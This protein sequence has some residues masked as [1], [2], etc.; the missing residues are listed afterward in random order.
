M[1]EYELEHQNT[2]EYKKAVEVL[3]NTFSH[4][5]FK[6]YQYRIINNI[7]K[8]NDVLAVMPTGYGKSLCFQLPPLITNELA[9]VISPLIALMA[10]QKAIMDDLGINSC[11]YNS[12]LTIKNKKAI[13]NDLIDGKYQIMYITPESLVNLH[14]LIDKIYEKHGICMIAI[15]EAHCLSSYGFDFRPKYLEIVNIRKIL[16]NV[17]VLAVTATAT[18]NVIVDIQRIMKMKNNDFITTS[19]DRPNLTINVNV[20][21]KN[22]IDQIVDI[23][24]GK[25]DNSKLLKSNDTKKIIVKKN[26]LLQ[27]GSS[28]VYCLTRKDTE[29]ITEQL[30]SLGI[31]TIAYHSGLTKMERDHAQMD[32][33]NDKYEC[34]AATLAFGMGINKPN[35][36]T[37]IHYGCPQNIESY[38][39]EIGRAGR[40]GEKSTCYLFYKQRDFIIQQKFINDIQDEKYKNHKAHLLSQISKY[41]SHNQCRR[42]YILNYFGQQPDFDNCKNCDVCNSVKQKIM[43]K[44]TNKDDYKIFQILNTILNIQVAKGFSFGSSTIALILKGSNSQK[45]KPWMKELTYFSAFKCETIDNVGKLI[46]TCHDLGYIE[47]HDIGNCIKVLQCTNEGIAFGTD[48]ESK[49][50]DMINSQNI[51]KLLF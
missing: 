48:Y 50:Q 6:P 13:E 44:K 33:M 5:S 40:D 15:D 41:V 46:Q 26:N 11:C 45:I 27:K 21:S 47:N 19:F 30:T 28:I 22:T 17:P 37:V 42:K 31:S 16:K 18:N 23:L 4:S 2:K 29:N 39:Q 49:M 8:G 35:V 20:Q 14:D 51:D 7:V 9:I 12:T 32:F 34:I 38:Y 24:R 36:R 10:D 43:S 25:T 1:D 3:K